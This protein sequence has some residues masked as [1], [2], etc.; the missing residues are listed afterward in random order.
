MTTRDWDHLIQRDRVHRD[1]YTDPTLFAEEM[2]RLWGGVW[3]YLCHESQLRDAHSF[4][5]VRMGL[6]DLIVTR[7]REGGIHALFNRCAHRAAIVCDAESGRAP[8]FTCPYHGWTYSPDGRLVGLPFSEGYGQE[9]DKSR[10]GLP[11]LPRVESF[12][13]F[14][15][16]TLNLDMPAL[17]EYLGAAGEVLGDWVD[18]APG[19]QLSVRAGVYRSSYRG[20]W[21]LAWDNAADMYHPFF[22]HRSLVEIT[23]ARYGGDAGA[24]YAISPDKVPIYSYAFENG[25]TFLHHRPG[26]GPSIFER[27]RPAPGTE[28]LAGQLRQNLGGG[29]AE[30]LERVPGQGMNL[31]IF[32]N[33]MI[34][35]SQIQVVEPVA[36]DRTN[37]VWHATTLD[38]APAE[39]NVMRMRIAEDFPGFGEVDDLEMFERCWQGLQMPEAEWVSCARGAQIA[40]AAV[41]RG[42]GTLVAFG[43]YEHTMRGYLA[44]YKR[45]MQQPMT[46]RVE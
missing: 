27:A 12:R 2:T 35:A 17:S 41:R 4:R 7:D 10:H 13:G 36:F 22:A 33:L 26:M 40:D 25:H 6:R 38:G 8:R 23:R 42:D 28:L 11:R 30:L 5:R 34:I 21:K 16:G 29:A 45:Y 32:P 39:A 14:V 9:F 3:T 20:N 46:L 18:R 15:F 37:I 1:V 31:N 19:G 24:T 44:A 43:S